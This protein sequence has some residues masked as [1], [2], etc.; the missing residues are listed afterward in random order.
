MLFMV[1]HKHSVEMCPGGSIKPDK[2]F[3]TKLQEGI[4]KNKVKLIE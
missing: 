3:I 2:Q 4:E 1:T